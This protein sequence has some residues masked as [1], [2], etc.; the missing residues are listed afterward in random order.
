MVGT[1]PSSP[2]S[3]A[4][5]REGNADKSRGSPQSGHR[6]PGVR[7]DGAV[8]GRETREGGSPPGLVTAGHGE[9]TRRH[10]RLLRVQADRGQGR[11]GAGSQLW[12]L[13]RGSSGQE[14]RM[15]A[16][17]EEDGLGNQEDG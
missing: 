8:S 16:S 5:A 12:A 7:Q 3:P 2:G 1:V 17:A 10:G 14:A 6:R 15:W 4:S 9:G 11:G 13:T